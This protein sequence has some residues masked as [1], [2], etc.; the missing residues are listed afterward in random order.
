[1]LLRRHDSAGRGV[2]GLSLLFPDLLREDVKLELGNGPRPLRKRQP[3]AHRHQRRREEA[4]ARSLAE[5]RPSHRYAYEGPHGV[6]G[7]RACRA[8]SS[9][10]YHVHQKGEP[11]APRPR[12]NVYQGFRL[13]P[14][15]EDARGISSEP[16]MR[17]GLCYAARISRLWE[18]AGTTRS[19]RV[20]LTG[21]CVRGSHGLHLYHRRQGKSRS[22]EVPDPAFPPTYGDMRACMP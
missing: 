11:V 14:C 21:I 9:L 1:M 16:E 7:A 5:K 8:E 20:G 12:A 15:A 13:G 3:A 4:G 22:L 2:M 19:P 18:I 10:R 17:A 6:I